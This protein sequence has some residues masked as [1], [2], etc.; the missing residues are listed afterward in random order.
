MH[1][2]YRHAL[3]FGRIADNSAHEQR[4]RRAKNGNDH[5][6]RGNPQHYRPMLSQGWKAPASI[7]ALY[8]LRLRMFHLYSSHLDHGLVH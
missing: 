7:S 8:I 3:A 1:G 5:G 4:Q 2:A 6:E